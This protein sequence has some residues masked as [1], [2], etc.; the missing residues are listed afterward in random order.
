[1]VAAFSLLSLSSSA[2]PVHMVPLLSGLGLGSSAAL[3]GTL[4]GPSQVASWLINTL[5]GKNLPHCK[6]RSLRQS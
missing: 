4:F 1:M 3:I 5:F 2:V 6:W